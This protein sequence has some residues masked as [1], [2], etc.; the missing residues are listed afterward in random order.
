MSY[1]FLDNFKMSSK[2]FGIF[3]GIFR[4]FLISLTAIISKNLIYFKPHEILFYRSLAASVLQLFYLK[5]KKESL[6]FEKLLKLEFIIYGSLCCICSSLFI[7][8][9]RLNSFSE[10]MILTSTSPIFSFM[11]EIFFKKHK[12]VMKEFALISIT[13]CGIIVLSSSDS[14]SLES[15]KNFNLFNVSFNHSICLLQGGLTAIRVDYEKRLAGK[16]Q[17]ILLNLSSL[18][19]FLV[20]GLLAGVYYGNFRIPNFQEFYL[21]VILGILIIISET[22]FLKSLKYE[23]A[24]IMLMIQSSRMFM[25]FFLEVIFLQTT[26]KLSYIIVSIIIYG[27]IAQIMIK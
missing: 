2:N 5:A 8:A 25:S 10:A 7:F 16:N 26:P 17:E 22:L 19:S 11:I 27:S 24:S 20:Y 18:S 1:G 4:S 13:F 15:F 21:L 9:L 14:L 3:A 12:F 6:N 23:K